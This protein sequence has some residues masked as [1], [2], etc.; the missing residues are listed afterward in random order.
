[1]IKLHAAP[2]NHSILEITPLID[3]VFLLLIFFLLTST[4]I[5]RSMDVDLPEARSSDITPPVGIVVSLLPDNSVHV[6]QEP[7]ALDALTGVLRERMGGA[8]DVALTIEA[9]RRASFERFA[10]VLDRARL[11]GAKQVNLATDL[12]FD[13]R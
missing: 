11:A 1:M 6:D 3:V 10:Q 2:R 12:F 8:A 13:K 9:D 4:S 7:V 5:Q